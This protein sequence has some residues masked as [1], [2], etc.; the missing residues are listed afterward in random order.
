MDVGFFF[1]PNAK[2]VSRKAATALAFRP[3]VQT[4]ESDVAMHD[5]VTRESIPAA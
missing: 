2:H 4:A 1:C 5:P 3:P